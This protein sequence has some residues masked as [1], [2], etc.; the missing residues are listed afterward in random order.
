MDT[1]DDV[2]V[3]FQLGD[4]GG[5]EVNPGGVELDECDRLFTG[6]AQSL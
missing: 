4:D 1:L 5:R 2:S 3:Q 6:L